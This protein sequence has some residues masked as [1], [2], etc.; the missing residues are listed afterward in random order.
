ML[1]K[2]SGKMYLAPCYYVITS[3]SIHYTK[4]YEAEGLVDPEDSTKS[5]DQCVR[6]NYDNAYN[7]YQYTYS[8]CADNVNPDCFTF[9][10]DNQV[11]TGY[12][13]DD[14]ESCPMDVVIPITIDE[15]KVKYIAVV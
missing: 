8:N 15:I 5:L 1:V 13:F 9:D 12:N 11:I 6:I 10:V 7:S 14:L 2:G 3:Y 4:L